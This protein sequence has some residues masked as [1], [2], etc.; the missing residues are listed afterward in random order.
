M[1]LNK[2]RKLLTAT[3]LSAYVVCPEAWR[4]KYVEN[5]PSERNVSSRQD[6]GKEM[7]REWVQQQDLSRT[8]RFYAKVVYLLLVSLV[9]IVFLLERQRNSRQY[10][11]RPE[12]A[13]PPHS[14]ES[15]EDVANGG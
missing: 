13:S 11:E 4:L 8:L 5:E 1:A 10:E 3:Q 7:R 9:I 12:T 6:R 14:V 15:S 2:S